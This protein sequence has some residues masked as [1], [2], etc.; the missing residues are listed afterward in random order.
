MSERDAEFFLISH[1]SLKE[2]LLLYKTNYLLH[3]KKYQ[4]HI[5]LGK[6]MLKLQTFYG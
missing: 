1:S 5:K 2:G 4:I 3:E 6:H